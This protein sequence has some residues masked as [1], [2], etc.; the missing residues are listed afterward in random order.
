MPIG[1]QQIHNTQQ[2]CNWE[3]VFSMWSVLYL[4]NATIEELLGVVFSMWSVLMLHKVL[5]VCCEFGTW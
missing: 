5:I 1:K 4:R 2:W 3:V